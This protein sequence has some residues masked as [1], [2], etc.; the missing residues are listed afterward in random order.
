MTSSAFIRG[1]EGDVDPMSALVSSDTSK[2]AENSVFVL[3]S[4]RSGSTLLRFLLDAHPELSC[5]AE[6]NIPNMCGHLASL[7]GIVT[8][9]KFSLE[10]EGSAG[11]LP[12]ELIRGVRHTIDAVIG[13][14]LAREGKQ[15]FCDKSIGT[16]RYVDLLRQV[17]P[18]AKFICLYRHPMDFI[19]S[20]LEA[21]PWGLS[22]YGFEPYI[23]MSPANSVNALARYWTDHT[24][25]IMQAADQYPDICHAIRYEDLADAPE[26]V[27][28]G[29][30]KFLDVS[31][32]PG[33]SELCFAPNRDRMGP[34]DFKIWYS[35][36]VSNG[37]IGNADTIPAIQI[38]PQ[39]RAAMNELLDKLGY[40]RVELSWG[41]PGSPSDPR[42]PGTRPA[43]EHGAS[44][45]GVDAQRALRL[46]GERAEAGVKELDDDFRNR[47]TPY[48]G[49]RLALVARPSNGSSETS[50]V[51]DIERGEVNV[52]DDDDDGY[53]WCVI[54]SPETWEGVLIGDIDLGIAVRHGNVRYCGPSEAD[55]TIMDFRVL[56][57]S[58]LLGL[59]T[60]SESSKE[61]S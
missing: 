17:Y 31:P 21:C 10:E 23:A 44:G 24:G 57:I 61:A 29:L 55:I 46:L 37:S 26:Q 43:S 49:G 19:R 20:G 42:L 39:V 12:E 51:L 7:W 5:P 58:E 15:R 11:K 16:S 8:K 30:F 28:A 13:T 50:W 48:V 27:T 36:R 6:T 53:Q 18:D 59:P 14:H 34:S 41:T 47:W 40:V 54:A 33:I 3:C 32:Q 22:G 45:G 2:V 1:T 60:L 56:M 52:D 38:P 4:A 25:W 35:S 9:E